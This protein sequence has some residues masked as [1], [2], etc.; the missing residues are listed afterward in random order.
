MTKIISF[1]GNTPEN[2]PVPAVVEALEA[3]LVRART[4]EIQAIASA[5]SLRYGSGT[6]T[7]W[8][9]NGGT[10]EALGFA[11]SCLHHRYFMEAIEG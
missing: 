9:G 4:G 10:T 7:G 11:I 3:L 2:E 5:Y 8:D 6:G 1:N